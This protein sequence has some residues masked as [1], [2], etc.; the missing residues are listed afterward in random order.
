MF[1]AVRTGP[2]SIAVYSHLLPHTFNFSDITWLRMPMILVGVAGVF[3]WNYY[4]KGSGG[5]R[6]GKPNPFD[7]VGGMGG[8]A[9]LAGLSG[10][11][12]LSKSDMDSLKKVRV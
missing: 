8:A 2:S 6:G 5:G 11:G 3:M 1:L 10:M 4:K 9:G 7:G 12:G